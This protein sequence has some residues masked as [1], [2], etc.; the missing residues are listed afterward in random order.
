MGFNL[1]FKGLILIKLLLQLISDKA[2][3]FET[4]QGDVS[5]FIYRV[6]IYMFHRSQTAVT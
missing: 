4:S 5:G 1:V 6:F 2:Q 3:S